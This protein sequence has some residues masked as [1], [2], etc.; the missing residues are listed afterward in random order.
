MYYNPSSSKVL[1][2][3]YVMAPLAS[4]DAYGSFLKILFK[5]INKII[6][7][8]K[9]PIILKCSYQNMFKTIVI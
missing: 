9:E 6:G 8:Q 1:N 5:C 4:D 7:I 2:F 3:F